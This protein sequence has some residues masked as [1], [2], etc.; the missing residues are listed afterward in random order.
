[1]TPIEETYHDSLPLL[2]HLI[3]RFQ[4]RHRGTWE[5]L[6]AEADHSFCLAHASHDPDKGEWTTW[7]WWKV[8]RGLQEAQRQEVGWMAHNKP[9]DEDDATMPKF[10]A[11]Q[12]A[13]QVS[14]DAAEVIGIVLNLPLEVIEVACQRAGKDRKPGNLRG[15]VV[16]LLRELGWAYS[17][18]ATAFNEIREAL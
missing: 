1:M 14:T 10:D 7:L 5:E 9:L 16:A 15:G 2:L 11:Q 8:W 12:F 4:T 3:Q 13:G 18:I 6:R 17:R